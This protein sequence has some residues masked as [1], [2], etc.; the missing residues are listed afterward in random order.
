MLNL[1]TGA[2]C[3]ADVSIVLVDG[4]GNPVVDAAVALIP[5]TADPIGIHAS[6]PDRSIDQINKRFSPRVMVFQ[7][8]TLVYFP[9]SDNIRH[10][11]YSFS[12]AK[13]FETK[14]Y[15]GRA[16]PP[17][18][19][20]KAGVVVL[21]CNIHDTMTAYLYVVDSPYYAKTDGAGSALITAPEALYTL[22]I[23]HPRFEKG[24]V[25]LSRDFLVSKRQESILETLMLESAAAGSVNPGG[26]GSG[27]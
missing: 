23:W 26:A 8:G 21:G 17:V 7:T 19:F 15:S 16:A 2:A 22:N 3:A 12:E 5:K 20:D 10:Q 13:K 18:L 27:P 11:V 4:D 6:P 1:L 24:R 25:A 9:N 14:L